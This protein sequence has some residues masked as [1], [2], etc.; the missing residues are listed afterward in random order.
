MV[1]G[2]T[3]H[4]SVLAIIQKNINHVC[5]MEIL[6]KYLPHFARAAFR[7]N[8]ERKMRITKLDGWRGDRSDGLVSKFA[9][10]ELPGIWLELN[11]SMAWRQ[12]H[13]TNIP[14]S[15]QIVSDTQTAVT[16]ERF[17]SLTGMLHYICDFRLILC[18]RTQVKIPDFSPW[19]MITIK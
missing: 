7:G 6:R 19:Y 16:Q 18:V 11:G 2:A 12:W 5:Y 14:Y 9:W 1:W 3:H 4:G 8:C 15:R 17:T 13:S 10:F